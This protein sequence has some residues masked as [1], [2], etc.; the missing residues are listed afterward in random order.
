MEKKKIFKGQKTYLNEEVNEISLTDSDIDGIQWKEEGQ[1]L[2]IIIRWSGRENFDLDTMITKLE[3]SW[4]TD[5]EMNIEFDK[6]WIG[7]PWIDTFKYEKKDNIWK[8]NFELCHPSEGFL[9]F[10]CNDFKFVI[11]EK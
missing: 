1:D 6:N 2:E 10:N 5:F 3:F 9:R 8:I 11:E 4:I 7:T